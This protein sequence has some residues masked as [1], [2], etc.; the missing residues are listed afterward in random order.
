MANDDDEIRLALIEM[1]GRHRTYGE[2]RVTE[3]GCMIRIGLRDEAPKSERLPEYAAQ[4][5]ADDAIRLAQWLLAA[6]MEMLNRQGRF[7]PKDWEQS[8]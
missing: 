5:G 3:N 6:A 2:L 8:E 7:D 1:D 4:L